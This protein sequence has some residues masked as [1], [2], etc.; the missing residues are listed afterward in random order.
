MRTCLSVFSLS[1]EDHA[2]VPKIKEHTYHKLEGNIL[3]LLLLFKIS[4]E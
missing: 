4:P 1:C 2:K 3:W